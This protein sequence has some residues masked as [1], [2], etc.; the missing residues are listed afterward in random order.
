[1]T[2]E[3]KDF[4]LEELKKELARRSI[5]EFRASQVFHWLYKQQVTSFWEMN[6]LPREMIKLLE[7]NYSLSAITAAQEFISKDGSRKY[8]FKLKDSNQIETVFI[9]NPDRQTV[10]LS[11]QVGCKFC[12]R[13]CASGLKK[14]V[15]NLTAAEIL[16]QL[17][18][19]QKKAG[20]RITNIVFMG[21]G[22]P[23]ENFDQVMKA[24][25]VINSSEGPEIAARKITIST[26]GFIPGIKKLAE[27]ELQLN[28]SVSLHATTDEERSELMPIN[29]TYPIRD[30]V[31]ACQNYFQKTKRIVTIEYV[32]LKGKNDAV[33]DARRLA[34]IVNALKGKVNLIPFNPYSE[35]NLEP[36]SREDMERFKYWLERDQVTVTIRDSRGADIMAACGQLAGSVSD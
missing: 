29:K 33:D 3:I 15:R 28:L 16:D 6:N 22:E 26:A 35:L 19:V 17:L 1:M 14:F 7:E 25:R 21:M 31:A 13:M 36:V 4:N 27:V 18:Y 5:P 2:M 20:G 23:L 8:L 9:P 11:T 10:C 30:L 32:L 24:I 34:G 12:C